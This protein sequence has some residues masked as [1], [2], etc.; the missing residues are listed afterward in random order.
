MAHARRGLFWQIYPTL[1]ASL[2][3]VA[4]IGALLFRL[5]VLP[6]KLAGTLHGIAGE[7]IHM[8]LLGVLL[9]VAAVVGLAAYPVVA[10]ITSRLEDLR[11]AVEAWG[12]GQLDRRASLEGGDEIAAVA[13]SFN[14]AADRADGLLKAHRTLLAH[15]SHELRSPLAR[16]ALAAEIL[17]DR[18][19]PDL[20]LAVRREIAEL[21]GLVEEILL[22]SRLD[23]GA[24]SLEPERVDL[25]ALAAEEAARAAVRL[26]DIPPGC[27]AFEV[28][29]SPRLL[30]RLIRN[31]LDNALKHGAPPIEVELS[32]SGSGAGEVVTVAVHDKGSGISAD[33]SERVFEPFYRPA[34]WTEEAGG[35]GLGLALVRQ[36]AERHGGQARC[37]AESAQG[38]SFFVSLP[39]SPSR[40]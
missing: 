40:C 2:I 29:G 24:A 5:F 37:G 39:A 6:M 23:H 4:V 19:D 35:W 38:A 33:L 30:R 27:A 31:L 13:A 8:H 1:L 36:I 3:L 18:A 16:L 34:G 32:R 9:S 26:R 20:S 11:L 12:G 14:A 25:L 17:A 28:I 21:D 10:H 7:G 15:A 22:A